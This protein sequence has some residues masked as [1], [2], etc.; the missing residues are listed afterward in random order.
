M[1][2]GTAEG[3]ARRSTTYAY[4]LWSCVLSMFSSSSYSVLLGTMQCVDCSCRPFTRSCWLVFSFSFF[5]SSLFLFLNLFLFLFPFSSSSPFFSSSD[6]GLVVLCIPQHIRQSVATGARQRQHHQQSST[7]A[8]SVV[9][10]TCN[11]MHPV[12]ICLCLSLFSAIPSTSILIS[13]PHSLGTTP[14]SCGSKTGYSHLSV[15]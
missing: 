11:A 13:A 9:H 12:V 4:S 7:R 1:K 15:Q 2:T 10:R 14:A 5:L 6:D 3:P 8:K